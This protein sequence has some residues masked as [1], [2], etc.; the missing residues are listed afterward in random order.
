MWLE[1]NKM[2]WS[3]EDPKFFI[4]EQNAA[5]I[6]HFHGFSNTKKVW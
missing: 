4:T 1:T 3:D 6:V 2:C 5:T